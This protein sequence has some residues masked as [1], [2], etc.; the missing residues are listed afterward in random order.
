MANEANKPDRFSHDNVRAWAQIISFEELNSSDIEDWRGLEEEALEPNIYLGYDFVRFLSGIARLKIAPTLL[1]VYMT[2]E[3]GTTLIGLLPLVQSSA[4]LNM[5]FP[6]LRGFGSRYSF[7]GGMLLKKDQAECAA[8]LICKLIRDNRW[9]WYGVYLSDLQQNTEQARIILEAIKANHC[10]WRVDK[11]YLRASVCRMNEPDKNRFSSV[12][13]KRLKRFRRLKRNLQKLGDVKWRLVEGAK[14]DLETTRSF[15]RLEH[16]GW[17]GESGSSLRSDATN[18]RLFTELVE[19]LARQGK[20]FFTELVLDNRVIGSTSNFRTD[21]RAFAFK[22]AW[23]P[24]YSEFSPGTM[25]EIE[26]LNEL[27]AGQNWGL[28]KMDSGARQGSYLEQ[29]WPNRSAV[30][31][32]VIVSNRIALV[33]SM[34]LEIYRYVKAYIKSLGAVEFWKRKEAQ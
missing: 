24:A 26:F 5:P 34:L 30:S 12:S 18:E 32:G 25:L 8:N 6:H 20:V 31:S 3:S 11:K 14:V 13:G 29:I 27:D 15:L 2:G 7:L 9:R 23:D 33:F 17:K 10:Y 22:V 1:R 16:M 19:A 28:R 21:D 4:M